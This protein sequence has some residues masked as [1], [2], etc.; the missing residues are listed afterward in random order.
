MDEKR[1]TIVDFLSEHKDTNPISFHMPGHKGREKLMRNCG[2]GKFLDNMVGND[3][4]EI[5][6]AD[7][8]TCPRSSLMEVAN[9]YKSNMAVL[10][11]NFLLGSTRV[12]GSILTAV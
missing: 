12:D 7:N 6:G 2:F 5:L 1:N 4:T 3:I 10:Q 9:R 11:Q 8:L